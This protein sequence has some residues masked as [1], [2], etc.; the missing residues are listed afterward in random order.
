MADRTGRLLRW[1][2]H[3]VVFLGFAGL[4]TVRGYGAVMLLPP[5]LLVPLAAIGER[6]E[7]EWP[8]FRSVKLAMVITYACFIPLSL[9]QLG[10]MNAVLAL[11]VFILVYLLLGEK[12]EKV[13][14][15]IHLMSFFLLLA[16]VVQ[17]P[18]PEIALVLAG[19]IV[20][21]VWAFAALRIEVE[22]GR[23]ARIRHAAVVMLDGSPGALGGRSGNVFD[24]GV[25]VSLTLL[26]VAAMALTV[27]IFLAT[28]RI[29][30]GIFG[31][32]DPERA[33]TGISDRVTLAGGM[34]IY[35]DPTAVMHVE[36]PD[37]PG[38]VF[39]PADGMYWR[40]TTMPLF[41][42][43]EWSRRP[44]GGHYQPGIERMPGNASATSGGRGETRGR[45]ENS[46]LVRQLV[47]ADT[48]RNQALPLLEL[49]QSVSLLGESER[50]SVRWD[51]AM[52]FTMQVTMRSPQPVSYEAYSEVAAP[53]AE[54]LRAAPEDY[55]Q[56]DPDDYALLTRHAFG[57]EALAQ[58]ESVV[59]GKT[60]AYDKVAALTGWLSG[61]DFLYTLN[62]PQLRGMDEFILRVRRG[63]CE[64]FASALA[65]MAR[66]QGIPARVVSGYRGGE[67]NP[68]DLSYTIRASMAH[69][70]V[71]VWF[72]GFGWV[73]F[74]PSPRTDFT[75]GGIN[76]L[77]LA[78]SR[79]V[80]QAKMFWYQ[81]VLAFQG[82]WRLD[83]LFGRSRSH[84]QGGAGPAG[85]SRTDEVSGG[86]GVSLPGGVLALAALFA[87]SVFAWRVVS[88]RR[89]VGRFPLTPDQ[90]RAVRFHA[91]LVGRLARQGLSCGGCAAEE[92]VELAAER[93]GGE[94]AL[95]VDAGVSAYN[96][97]R[98]GGRPFDRARER[99]L[100]AR[101]R[102]VFASAEMRAGRG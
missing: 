79:R 18:E 88:R 4:S 28:P 56:M 55:S 25:F 73:R 86:L 47:F 39:V 16:A 65:L 82:G 92:L 54:A 41:S 94:A 98:F 13:Y 87:V 51:T 2:T 99:E 64:L 12:N 69:L 58:V 37:E 44:L 20:A 40:V 30:A 3:A 63:H 102:Q 11:V 19:F 5:L 78:W 43:V 75:G 77:R 81:D 89:G 84:A 22:R 52:D 49:A 36:F 34:S 96:D 23:T 62:V 60:T 91:W 14:Y 21:I 46:R 67:F 33:V 31:R 83:R 32:N 26:S 48:I 45:V 17:D 15:Q 6:L 7:R 1:A 53:D 71:E 50:V 38:G 100:R 29:E 93:G 66:S 97:A 68:N 35:Q 101:L 74:D 24:F 57:R 95:A 27:G 80:L 10:L 59:R 76:Q 72:N 90:R 42:G 85:A 8:H 9:I 70:W 61:P